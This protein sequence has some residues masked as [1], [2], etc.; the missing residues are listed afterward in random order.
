LTPSLPLNE[1][2]N[3][4]RDLRSLDDDKAARVFNSFF[5]HGESDLDDEVCDPFEEDSDE[6]ELA[7]NGSSFQSPDSGFVKDLKIFFSCAIQPFGSRS[8]GSEFLVAWGATD[9]L[10][11]Q[12]GILFD[13]HMLNESVVI[14]EEGTGIGVFF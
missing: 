9:D 6:G 11:N 4:F 3:E 5:S 14:D 2:K 13:G 1:V 8:K 10:G 7:D 12:S